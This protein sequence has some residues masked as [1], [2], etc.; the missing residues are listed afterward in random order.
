MPDHIRPIKFSVVVATHNHE[1]HLIKALKS[2][3]S[4]EHDYNFEVIIADDCSIDKTKEIIDLFQLRYPDQ[5][6]PLY[7]T[8]K[9]GSSE[10]ILQAFQKC[11][12]QYTF[13]IDPNDYWTDNEKIKKQVLFLDE[14]P[15]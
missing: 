9:T 3:F 6:I 13:L 15:E 1:L 8:K 7:H 10:N 11:K 2:V 12:G 4:Q 5:V 14:Q